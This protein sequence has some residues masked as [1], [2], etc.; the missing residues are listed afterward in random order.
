[1][2]SDL[3]AGL[4]AVTAVVRARVELLRPATLDLGPTTMS[5]V[6]M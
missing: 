4:E 6:T 2:V 3:K 5:D 1:V